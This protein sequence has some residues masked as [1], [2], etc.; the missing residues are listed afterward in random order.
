MLDI[1]ESSTSDSASESGAG[2]FF[3]G[4][5]LDVVLPV[6]V[7]WVNFFG[8]DLLPAAFAFG[9]YAPDTVST[10]L[11]RGVSKWIIPKSPR[12]DRNQTYRRRTRHEVRARVTVNFVDGAFFRDIHLGNERKRSRGAEGE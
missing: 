10:A 11:A 3:A 6:N 2:R 5:F 4:A 9:F 12:D 7:V 8:P 1:T